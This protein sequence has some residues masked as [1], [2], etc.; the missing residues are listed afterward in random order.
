MVSVTMALNIVVYKRAASSLLHLACLSRW[1]APH[2]VGAVSIRKMKNF[3]PPMLPRKTTPELDESLVYPPTLPA[4]SSSRRLEDRGAAQHKV[5]KDL[6][7]RLC[8]M[9]VYK[10]HF[11][12]TQTTIKHIRVYWDQATESHIPVRQSLWNKSVPTQK[13]L[14]WHFPVSL[15]L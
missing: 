14:T 12:Y 3:G 6:V 7:Q 9:S 2:R 5:K 10:V 8:K 15:L 1:A 13:A 4:I 11:L